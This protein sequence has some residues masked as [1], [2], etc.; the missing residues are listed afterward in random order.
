[1]H[2]YDW[3]RRE[4]R[5]E[6]NERWKLILPFDVFCNDV[7][8][9]VGFAYLI[10]EMIVLSSD[11]S[12]DSKGPSIA[13]VP[14]EGPSIQGLL[15]W[16]GYETVEEYLEETFF[17]STYKDTTDKNITDEDTIHESYS[18][19]SK[20]CVLGLA[21]VYTWDD[22]LMKFGVRKPESCADK[23]KGKRKHL[24]LSLQQAFALQLAF[25]I[26]APHMHKVRKKHRALGFR[27]LSLGA[28]RKGD[29][30]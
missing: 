5:E 6:E 16:Y 21:N 12:D 1:T 7:R 19:K 2:S 30:F 26:E 11:S 15:D 20:G 29:G 25:A 22:I 17:P 4:E 23:A 13:S 18:P 10:A 27:A 24:Q 14:K 8:M 3:C 28:P 9:C